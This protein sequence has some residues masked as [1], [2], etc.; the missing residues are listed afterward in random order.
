MKKIDFCVRLDYYDRVIDIAH[1][2]TRDAR[3]AYMYQQLANHRVKH[4]G[5]FEDDKHTQTQIEWLS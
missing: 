1:F 5:W 4:I 2:D 3:D